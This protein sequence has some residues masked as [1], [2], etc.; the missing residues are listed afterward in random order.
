M[1]CCYD[2]KAKGI[3]SLSNENKKHKTSNKLHLK[4]EAYLD[5]IS[6]QMELFYFYLWDFRN[7]P[8][9]FNGS[10]PKNRMQ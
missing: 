4:C 8:L 6:L 3:V 5:K 10:S 1:P 7:I 2:N 9:K